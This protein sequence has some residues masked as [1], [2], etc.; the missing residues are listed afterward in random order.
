MG[1][2]RENLKSRGIDR[3][4]AIAI[5]VDLARKAADLGRHVYSEKRGRGLTDRSFLAFWTL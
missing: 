2:S 4:E 1:E 3:P 5:C